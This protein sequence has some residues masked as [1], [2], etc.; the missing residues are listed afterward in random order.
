[1]KNLFLSLVLVM[2]GL[3]SFSQ[4]MKTD[5]TLVRQIKLE[6]LVLQYINDYR[7]SLGIKP[8]KW[9]DKIYVLA[10]HQ[11]RYLSYRGIE[12]SHFQTQDR[13]NHTELRYLCDR[14][15]YFNINTQE[16]IECLTSAFTLGMVTQKDYEEIAHEIVNRWINSIAHRNGMI[17]SNLE[18]GVVSIL[19]ME[20]HY[21]C[22]VLVMSE[23]K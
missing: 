4:E 21:M 14:V 23:Y 12:L 20:G 8:V 3:V 17:Q 7:V 13:P 10:S 11:A 9:D 6:K 5:T 18:V 16:S 22:P 19:L 1:M 15:K 2:V